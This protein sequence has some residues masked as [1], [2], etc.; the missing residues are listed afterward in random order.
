MLRPFSRALSALALLTACGSNG[1]ATPPVKPGLWKV[2]DADT[3]IYLF[4]TI[5]ML[6]PDYHWRTAAFD[7]AL[8]KADQLILEVVLDK[9]PAKTGAIMAKL[10]IS[11]GLP[12]LVE[13]VPTEKRAALE[14][15]IAQSK[16]P[17]DRINTLETWAAATT[18]AATTLRQ[19]N[20]SATDGVE[21]QLTS[22]FE[23]VGKPVSGLET[24][25]QQLGYFDTLPEAVQRQFLVS[26]IDSTKDAEAEFRKMMIAWS[27]GDTQKIAATFDEE[28]LVS[29]ALADV[30]LKRRNA[31]WTAWVKQRL[32]APGTVF[33]AVGAGHLAG[34]DSVQTMLAKEGVKVTRVQ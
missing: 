31:S 23:Q 14:A 7:K 4:G 9:D 15:L 5:H 1:V 10:G 16:I 12:P 20:I 3:T 30:L 27:S 32:D 25:E 26:V 11:P 6:P 22:N 19:A 13:R 24:T 8:G 33:V 2:A 34:K 28:L 29:P 21:R 17:V 18:L